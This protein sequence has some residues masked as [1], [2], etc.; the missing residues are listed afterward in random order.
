MPYV[1]LITVLLLCWLLLVARSYC[2]TNR[3]HRRGSPGL[4]RYDDVG[5]CQ[6]VTFLPCCETKPLHV[7][8]AWLVKGVTSATS[9]GPPACVASQP[10]SGPI[11]QLL[12]SSKSLVCRGSLGRE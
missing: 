10:P 12:G 8:L 5:H 4:R 2:A 1:G 6:G 11:T 3:S 7:G 9:V